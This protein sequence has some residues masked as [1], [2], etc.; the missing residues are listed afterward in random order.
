VV[1]KAQQRRLRP[2]FEQQR[3]NATGDEREVEAFRLGGEP[4]RPAAR[5]P[6]F[7]AG[8]R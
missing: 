7:S 3:P 1:G 4:G 2:M 5:S 6:P 8:C